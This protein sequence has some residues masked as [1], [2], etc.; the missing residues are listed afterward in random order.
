MLTCTEA[1]LP[2]VLQTLGPSSNAIIL[3]PTPGYPVGSGGSTLGYAQGQGLDIDGCQCHT[4]G[5]VSCPLH[6]MG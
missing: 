3:V 5:W 2:Q 4:M 6:S 1:S